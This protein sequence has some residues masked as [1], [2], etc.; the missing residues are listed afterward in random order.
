MFSDGDG[1]LDEEVEVLGDVWFQTDGFHDA[2]HLVAVD[3][4]NLCNSMGITKNDT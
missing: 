4:S 1:A 2:K 3:E